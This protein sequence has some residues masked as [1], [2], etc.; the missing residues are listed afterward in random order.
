LKYGRRDALRVT[1]DDENVNEIAALHQG[2]GPAV[3]RDLAAL[4]VIAGSRVRVLRK[5]TCP[6]PPTAVP[7][8]STI[9]PA[10]AMSRRGFPLKPIFFSR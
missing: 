3:L 7:G 1:D 6:A 10:S 2:D 8:Q 5:F 9:P 4:R